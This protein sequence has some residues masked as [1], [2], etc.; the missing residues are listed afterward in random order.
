MLFNNIFWD[1]RAGTRAGD[2]VTGIGVA[3]D[4]T[5]IN[6]WDLGVA[7]GIRPALAHEL[8]RCRP[9]P[10]PYLDRPTNTAADPNVVATYDTSVAFEAWRT[11]PDFVGAMLV[12]ADLPPNLLGNYHLT[13]TS[14]AIQRRGREQDRRYPD[15]GRTDHRL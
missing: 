6:H 2:T 11:N 13:A 4:A 7:D 5:P 12:A 3:G 10:A 8:G 15:R 14:P 9:P 1:N